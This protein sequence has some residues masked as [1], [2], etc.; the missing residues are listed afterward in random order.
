MST[1]IGITVNP[2]EVNV[3]K[4][5]FTRRFDAAENETRYA[6]SN[7]S[8]QGHTEGQLQTGE[9]K[10]DHYKA[11]NNPDGDFAHIFSSQIVFNKSQRSVRT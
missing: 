3:S 9:K 7:E 10:E 11:G 6:K 5:S 2:Y 4:K 8:E 1:N